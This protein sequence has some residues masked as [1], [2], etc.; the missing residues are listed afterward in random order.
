MA[1]APMI[2]IDI[3]EPLL[4]KGLVNERRPGSLFNY[5]ATGKR[6]RVIDAAT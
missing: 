4:T 2:S 5:A 6:P 1:A 3:M